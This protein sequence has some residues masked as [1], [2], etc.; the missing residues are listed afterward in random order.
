MA[1]AAL[2]AFPLQEKKIRKASKHLLVP[3]R[4][5]GVCSPG[6]GS[7]E[8]GIMQLLCRAL[9]SAQ[10]FSLPGCEAFI[11]AVIFAKVLRAAFVGAG[12]LSVRQSVSS[13]G[14]KMSFPISKIFSSLLPLKNSKCV[15]SL[16]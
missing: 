5:R 8:G 9:H 4:N 6:V 2:K 16:G 3:L 12:V 14:L 15:I 7:S 1:G 11:G 10:L 13:S